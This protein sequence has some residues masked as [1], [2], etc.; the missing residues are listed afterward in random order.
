VRERLAQSLHNAVWL[1]LG[2]EQQDYRVQRPWSA[3]LAQQSQSAVPLDAG[4]R[5]VE[6]F[7]R[8]ELARQLLILGEPGAGKTTIMLELAQDLL[9][10]AMADKAEPIPVLIDLSSWK[11]PEQPFFVWLVQRGKSFPALQ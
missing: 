6:V 1:T 5:I 3:T 9:Q 2:I 10:R 4:T 8:P 11:N 7:D